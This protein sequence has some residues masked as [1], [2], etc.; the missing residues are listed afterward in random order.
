MFLIQPV[1]F[2]GTGKE[3]LKGD[4]SNFPCQVNDYTVTTMNQWAVGSTQQ[5]QFNGTAVH[6]G[7]SCQISVTT[8]KKPTADSKFFVIRSFEGN[9]PT[10][11]ADGLNYVEGTNPILQPQ[12]F[13]VP[14]EL[15]D[16]E[17]TAMVSWWNKIGNR[18]QYSYCS[19]ITVSGGAKDASELTSFPPAAVANVGAKANGCATTERFDYTFPNPGKNPVHDATKGPFQPLCGAGTGGSPGASPFQVIPPSNPGVSSP[20]PVA[21]APVVSSQAPPAASSQA[22]SAAPPA[23][24]QAPP[25]NA[26]PADPKPTTIVQQNL[27]VTAPTPSAKP[28]PPVSSAAPPASPA[29]PGQACS[30]DG[31]LVCSA[32]GKQFALCNHGKAVFQAVALGTTCSDGKIAKRADY[33]ST[34]RTLYA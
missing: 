14:A 29:V 25:A 18:E 21:P 17:L 27:T 33:A 32:D 20:A 22:S 15:P 12:E 1:P 31:S 23:S 7:G 16:G 5:F 13:I 2:A 11:P 26:G 9:C 28:S 34:L 10:A 30:P 8:D 19:P 4:G 24:S 3:P 6:G